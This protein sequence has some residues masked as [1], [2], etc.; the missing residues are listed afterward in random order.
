MKTIYMFDVDGTLTSPRQQIEETF[1]EVFLAWVESGDKIVYLVTGSDIGKTREQLFSSFI[2]QCSGV[3]TC[4]GNVFHSKNKLIYKNH[5]SL[6]GTFIED[7][8]L[9]LDNSLWR[10]K[11]GAHIEHRDG[12]LNFSTVGRN[13]SKDLREAYY[14]W[15]KVSQERLDIVDYITGLYPEFE[16]AIGGSISVDI[17]PKGKNKSQVV[18]KIWQLHGTD[19]QMVFVGDRNAPGGNDW[20]LAQ[21]LD[22][23][24]NCRWFQVFSHNDTLAL[25]QNNE[26][27]I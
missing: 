10:R 25:I 9:Y 16:V 5:L 20:P 2:D 1:A 11:T 7:L 12:M 15:D 4:S 21:R 23:I 26:L 19:A 17:Y 22:T 3:F 18:D 27:F 8:N 6:P 13:A 14:K 24:K